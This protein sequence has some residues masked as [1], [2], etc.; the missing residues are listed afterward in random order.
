M[1]GSV[2]DSMDPICDDLEAEHAELDRLVADLDE[3]GWDLPT[4]A[5]GW[6]VRDQISHLAFFDEAGR[7]AATDPDRFRAQAKAMLDALT[8]DPDA[9]DVSV[10][11]GRASTGAE[12]LAWWRQARSD[13]VRVF[14]TLDP[15]ARL[16]WYGP[17]MGARSFATARL[18]ETWAH[19][20]DVAD[21]LGVG[22]PATAR[23]RHVAH[24]GIGARPFAY[25]INR[26]DLPESGIRIELEAPDG[27]TWTW[28]DEGAS[29]RITGPALDFCLLVT[30]RRHFDDVD[31]V[32]EGEAAREWAGIAQSFAGPPGSGRQPGQFR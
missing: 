17:D 32:V 15:R 10:Q 11:R 13:V 29:D 14:R 19:G 18:M 30:Q 16:P 20:Q 2:S 21:A 23:L 31:L 3:A 6:A 7:T 12:L 24:I 1:L 25:A 27:G 28:G 4:P 9:T 5:A 26:M 8:D 22:R